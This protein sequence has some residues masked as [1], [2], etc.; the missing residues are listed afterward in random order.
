MCPPLTQKE[1][2]L[3]KTLLIYNYYKKVMNVILTLI[4]YDDTIY[5]VAAEK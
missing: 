5:S 1:E 3:H 4:L 2:K